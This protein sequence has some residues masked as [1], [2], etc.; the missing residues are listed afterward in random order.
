MARL[1]TY[2]LAPS[3]WPKS[4]NE[5][6]VI[7]GAEAKHMVSVLRTLPD[8]T[9]R[10][11]DGQGNDGL[12]TVLATSKRRVS[13][14]TIELR[15]TQP[16]AVGLSVAI[17][18]GKSKRRNYFLEK[19]VELQ[20][21]EVLFWEAQRSQGHMP[22]AAKD[23]WIDKCVQAAKQ[24]GNPFIPQIRMMGDMNDLLSVA[25]QYDNCFMA[26]EGQSVDTPLSPTLLQQGKS[27]VVIGP[28]GGLDEKEVHLFIEAN[29]KPV[30]LG[31]SIL[32]WE[33]AATYCLSLA[34][35]ARQGIL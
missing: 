28:E 24:C 31:N 13:L 6:V 35:C 16:P 30:S 15:K 22:K 12:F 3:C 18:W 1:N 8:D 29:F 20:G 27:L 25:S 33:T 4:V 21:F 5:T 11:F 19:T 10:L 9:V 17:A 32:R 14:E 2:F 23:S 7:E 26:W 34:H